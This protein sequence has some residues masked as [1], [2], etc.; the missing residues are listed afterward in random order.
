[1]F[2]KYVTEYSK[3]KTGVIIHIQQIYTT[4]NAKSFLRMKGND[5]R[6]KD[7]RTIKNVNKRILFFH[8]LSILFFIEINF[9]E[10]SI[11]D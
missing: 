5:S 3:K 1:M 7:M 4:E 2:F 8:L 9:M 11:H 6:W 10:H